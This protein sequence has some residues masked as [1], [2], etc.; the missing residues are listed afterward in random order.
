MVGLLWRYPLGDYTI[1]L[2][3]AMMC[4]KNQRA[5]DLA[6]YYVF[7]TSRTLDGWLLNQRDLL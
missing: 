4:L 2:P 6:Q 1:R 5:L 3:A 7:P